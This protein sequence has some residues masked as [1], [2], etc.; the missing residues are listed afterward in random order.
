MK[1]RLAFFM[2]LIFKEKP[3]VFPHGPHTS[4]YHFIND[5][6]VQR[7]QTSRQS[8]V[9]I[10]VS[11]AA[12]PTPLCEGEGEDWIFELNEIQGELKF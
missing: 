4:K 6:L 11:I 5:N 10:G 9:W 3:C 12:P 2:C 1:F 7:Q 8:I